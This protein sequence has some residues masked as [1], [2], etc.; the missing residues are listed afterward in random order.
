M[1]GCGGLGARDAML[2][3]E[4]SRSVL[5]DLPFFKYSEVLWIL[6]KSLAISKVTVGCWN[7]MAPGCWMGVKAMNEVCGPG[8]PM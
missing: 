2:V 6:S 1:A 7:T 4:E 5:A 8:R 3:D